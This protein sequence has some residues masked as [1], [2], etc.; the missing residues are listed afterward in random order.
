MEP[1]PASR[2]LKIT[3][4][5]MFVFL[6]APVI[7][8]FPISFSSDAYMNFPPSGFSTRWYVEFLHDT[9]M[10][11][12][13]WT[14]LVLAVAVTALCL[15][16]ALPAA[17][18]LTRLRFPGSE[19]LLALFTA[20]LLLPLIVLGLAILIVFASRGLLA[21]YTGLTIAHLVITLPYALRVLATSLSG[22]SLSVEE[23]AATLGA[24][25]L[26]VFRRITLPMMVPGIVATSALSFLVSF[27]EVVLSLFLTGPRLTTLPVAMYHHVD[28]HADPLVAAVSVVLI[29]LTLAVVLTVDRTVGLSRTFIR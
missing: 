14:S 28:T 6:L 19:L 15:L 26:T 21:T 29:L 8:V 2:A 12:A 17:Y 13:L 23:A 4:F 9:R 20:P 7:L 25:P 18:A 3:A 24:S 16:I 5:I 27:D 1:L 22:L 10:L 11:R